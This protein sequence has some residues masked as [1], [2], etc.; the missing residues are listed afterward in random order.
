MSI[1]KFLF[2]ILVFV[3]FVSFG[4]SIVGFMFGLGLLALVLFCVD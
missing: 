2:M 3:W 4:A 1:E